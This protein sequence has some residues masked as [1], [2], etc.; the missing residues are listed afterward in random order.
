V[1][2]HRAHEA[3]QFQSNVRS[4]PRHDAPRFCSPDLRCTLG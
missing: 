4:A 1:A 3:D 2:P